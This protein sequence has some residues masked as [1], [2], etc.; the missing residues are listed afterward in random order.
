MIRAIAFVSSVALAT[1]RAR[2]WTEP[3]AFVPIVELGGRCGPFV[4]DFLAQASVNGTDEWF[5]R[6]GHCLPPTRSEALA[7]QPMRLRVVVRSVLATVA[8]SLG[9]IV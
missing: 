9:R 2:L 3:N 5:A 6:T 7:M 8:C 4:G 1:G